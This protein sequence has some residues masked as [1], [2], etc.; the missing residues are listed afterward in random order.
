MQARKH[1][2]DVGGVQGA[3]VDQHGTQA[4]LLRVV[5]D[6]DGVLAQDHSLRQ[7]RLVTCC[8]SLSTAAL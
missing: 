3:H 4:A 1:L 2:P 8:G 5:A 6:L 7:R